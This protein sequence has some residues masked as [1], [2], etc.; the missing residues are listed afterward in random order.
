MQW[1][2]F[3]VSSEGVSQRMLYINVRVEETVRWT[4]TCEGNAKSVDSGSA[5]RWACS[6]NVSKSTVNTVE[7]VPV[8]LIHQPESHTHRV[9]R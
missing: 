1:S 5:K 3:Q 8:Q 2:F 4:C 7:L 9:I 6:Q